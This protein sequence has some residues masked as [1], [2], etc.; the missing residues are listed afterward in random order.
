MCNN[1]KKTI[2]FL[3]FFLLLGCENIAHNNFSSSRE[4]IN[5][6]ASL[7]RTKKKTIPLKTDSAEKQKKSNQI[8]TTLEKFDFNEIKLVGIVMAKSENIAIIESPGKKGYI[9]KIGTTLGKNNGKI[10]KIY[11]DRIIIKEKIK[12]SNGGLII[13]YQ[14]MKLDKPANGN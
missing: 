13:N 12:N 1:F 14:E 7:I 2:L 3:T 8:S 11:N 10:I 5:P 9:V 4:T 6:F